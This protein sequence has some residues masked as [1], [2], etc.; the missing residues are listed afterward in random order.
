MKEIIGHTEKTWWVVYNDLS[1]PIHYGFVEVGH[2]MIAGMDI[3]ETFTNE[4]LWYQRLIVL[5]IEEEDIP[6]GL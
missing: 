3:L 1:G 6:L 4:D 5:G 2:H